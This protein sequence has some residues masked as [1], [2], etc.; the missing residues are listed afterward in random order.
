VKIEELK[1]RA[2]EACQN[3][4]LPKLEVIKEGL[5]FIKLRL[6]VKE[7]VTVELYF[8]EETQTLTTALLVKGERVFGINGYPRSG[9]WHIHP[10][11]KVEEH[12]E[13][14]SMEIEKIL[15]EYANVL[16]RIENV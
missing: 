3:L 16:K 15:Q 14:A 1:K 10:F 12:R 13:I 4:D 2:G 9:T 8:N 6:K 11:G 7:E 5:S